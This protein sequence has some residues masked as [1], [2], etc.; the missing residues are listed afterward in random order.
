MRGLS[1]VRGPV[2]PVLVLL[3]AGCARPASAPAPARPQPPAGPVAGRSYGPHLA[4]GVPADADPGDELL[5]DH[6]HFVLSYDPRRRVANWVGWR[7]EAADLGPVERRDDFH[8]DQLLPAPFVRVGP[9]DYRGS[10]FDRGHLCPS[11]DR[12]ATAEANSATF[13]MT[14]IHPQRPQLNRGPWSR[15]EEFARQRARRGDRLLIVAGGLFDAVTPAAGAQIAVPRASYKILVVLE[16]G[17]AVST[18][19]AV[20]AVIMP[21][22]AEVSGT[23]WPQYLVT[24]DE[25]ERASGY[26]FLAAIPASVA[27]HLEARRAQPP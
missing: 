23:R 9:G 20:Y 17:A 24:V 3:L 10:G 4:L 1:T 8:P 12:T 21:N 19:T 6:R 2:W 22:S 15:L 18:D 5:L 14:N 25:I 26:D 7:L 13:V 11:A 27:D 16:H